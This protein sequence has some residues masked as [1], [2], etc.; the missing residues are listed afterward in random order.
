[1]AWVCFVALLVGSY[2]TLTDMD[3]LPVHLPHLT[4]IYRPFEVTNFALALLLVFRTDASYARWQAA[5]DNWKSVITHS[6]EIMRLGC[7]YFHGRNRMRLDQLCRWICAYAWCL[8]DH[9]LQGQT[10]RESLTGLLTQREI[11]VLMDNSLE[12]KPMQVLAII[13]QLINRVSTDPTLRGAMLES[14]ARLEETLADCERILK[15]PI[16]RSYTR[17][18][19]RF[20]IAYLTFL[21]L[22]MWDETSWGVVPT[23]GIVA[24][25]LLGIDEIGVR[26]RSALCPSPPFE[27]FRS[28]Q[29][30]LILLLAPPSLCPLIATVTLPWGCSPS[31]RF[32]P[33]LSP[34][35]PSFGPVSL[36]PS[37]PLT[38]LPLFTLPFAAPLIA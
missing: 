13:S 21:P 4:V 31:V 11:D 2:E 3:V 34:Y 22:A 17:H 14:V 25:F 1:M 29:S 35:P 19:S 12:N 32:S 10:L 26:P 8:R 16:P 6:R 27:H 18:T 15:T 30:V 37:V 38:P 36:S 33:S 23:S 9:L 7:E 5:R 28:P 24:F 20:I